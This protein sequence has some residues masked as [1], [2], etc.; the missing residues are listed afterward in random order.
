M[1]LCPFAVHKLIP[2]GSSDPR[3][4][5][6]AAILHV[7]AGNASSLY[8]YFRFRSGGIESHF[9][10][11]L[12]GTIEQYRDTDFQ[13][14]ANLDAN[15]FAIS[16]ETQGFGGG[17]WTA[18][19]LVSIKR[20]LLWLNKVEGIPVRKI[21]H[22]DGS[23]VGY[24]TQFGAPSHWTPVAK[25]CPGPERI[26]QFNEVLVPWFQTN[27]EVRVPAPLPVPSLTVVAW[28]VGPANPDALTTLREWTTQHNPD[29]IVLSEA[30]KYADVLPKLKGFKVYQE[31]PPKNAD[32]SDDTGDVAILTADR[33]TVGFK[34]IDRMKLPWK[35]FR[36]NVL[37]KPHAYPVVNVKVRGKRWRVRGSHWPTHGFSGGNR[38]AVMESARASKRWLR[39]GL[40]VPSI[41]VGDL[42]E[43]RTTLAGWYGKRFKVFGKGIDVAVTRRVL[44]AEW[45][46]LP[47]GGSDHHGRLYKFTAKG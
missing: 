47:K 9:F 14:D 18:A 1:A 8:D 26:K 30:A 21:Q 39:R 45:K 43:T 40:K 10:I 32:R 24:H 27:P 28:N 22:W 12:D 17:K 3:I 15:D 33:V 36:Y 35:V 20:L 13:A 23:G 5:A 38:K 7:D 11:K 31:K 4:T 19:Q 42:N 34:W 16:I 44:D 6:R 46:E 25:S 37:H 41:D 2:P 29:V